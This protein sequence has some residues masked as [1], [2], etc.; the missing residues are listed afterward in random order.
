MN[1]KSLPYHQLPTT[2]APDLAAVLTGYHRR[3]VWWNFIRDVSRTILVVGA[4]ILAFCLLDRFVDID[5]RWRTPFPWIAFALL[6]VMLARTVGRLLGRADY[7]RIA[8]GL[9]RLANDDRDQLRTTLDFA[10]HEKAGGFFVAMSGA[11]ALA[12]WQ[13]QDGAAF[14]DGRRARSAAVSALIF[15]ALVV[16]LFQFQYLRGGLLWLR[17]L[18]PNGNFPRPSATWFSIEKPPAQPLRT[19]DDLPIRAALSGRKLDHPVP[20]LKALHP[21]GTSVTRKL[22]RDAQGSWQVRLTNLKGNFEWYLFM[23]DV[24]SEVYQT[25]VLPRPTVGKVEVGYA[26][27]KYSRLK[28][29]TETLR[30]RTVTALQGTKVKLK[31]HTNLELSRAIGLVDGE[32]VKFRIQRKNPRIAIL[33]LMLDQ[34]KKMTL[35]LRSVNGVRSKQELPFTFRAI[36]DNIP[37]VSIKNQ[38]AGKSFYVTD[39]I[40]LH[41][42]A[43]DDIGLAELMLKSVSIGGDRGDRHEVMIDIDLKKYGARE[44]EGRTILPVADLLPSRHANKVGLSLAAI[45][46]N[47]REGISQLVPITIAIDSFDRQLRLLLLSFD[48]DRNSHTPGRRG[49]NAIERSNSLL[50]SLKMIKG[51]LAVLSDSL[52]ADTPVGDNQAEVVKELQELLRGV[53]AGLPYGSYWFFDF[54]NASFLPRFRDYGSYAGCWSH[55]AAPGDTLHA[56]FDNAIRSANPKGE[57]AKMDAALEVAIQQPERVLKRLRI[58]RKTARLELCGYLAVK[59]ENSVTLAGR[60]QWDDPNFVVNTKKIARQIIDIMQKDIPQ[61]SLQPQMKMLATAAAADAAETAFHQALPDIA[62]LS[63]RFTTMAWEAGLERPDQG[64]DVAALLARRPLTSS[65]ANTMAAG[66]YL[67]VDDFETDEHQLLQLAFHFIHAYT[68]QRT[69]FQPLGESNAGAAVERTAYF[70]AFLALERL[71]SHAETFRHELVSGKSKAGKPPF[72]SHWLRLREDRLLVHRLI[73]PI[74]RN[75]ADLQKKAAP[76]LRSLTLVDRWLPP[77]DLDSKALPHTLRTWEVSAAECAAELNPVVQ[78]I[79]SE[80]NADIVAR[81]PLVADALDAYCRDLKNEIAHIEKIKNKEVWELAPM[82]VLKIRLMAIHAAIIKS[83]DFVELAAIYNAGDRDALDRL[84]PL[85]VL[86][87]KVVEHFEKKVE[88]IS[89]QTRQHYRPQHDERWLG[90]IREYNNVHDMLAPLSSILRVPRVDDDTVS[91]LLRQ[92]N[93]SYQHNQEATAV[94]NAVERGSSP[95]LAKV[96]LREASAGGTDF[97]GMLNEIY[98]STFLLHEALGQ[99]ADRQAVR[100][101]SLELTNRLHHFETLPNELNEMQELFADIHASDTINDPGHGEA[102]KADTALEQVGFAL[103]AADFLAD[104]KPMLDVPE[105][106]SMHHVGDHFTFFQTLDLGAL[107]RARARSTRQTEADRQR[108]RRTMSALALGVEGFDKSTVDWVL[109]ESEMNRRKA[110]LT[111][112][113]VGLGGIA[114]SE[115]FANLKLPKHLYLELK[116]ARAKAMPLLFQARCYDYLNRILENA[117]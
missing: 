81:L 6:L 75:N 33:Y 14:V 95:P 87:G 97:S 40:V 3:T 55:L 76:L 99:P 117:R 52:E 66:L 98:Y 48:G 114:P 107:Y 38:L 18:H 20:M 100:R 32:Q 71:Q 28:N 64:T 68:G 15:I 96:W 69:P 9:D 16:G 88:A 63:Q 57:L 93:I 47:G 11:K 22:M 116:R 29:K 67:Q 37:S 72:E 45:D 111:L 54:Q 65:V 115:D 25:T 53:G 90:K 113:R 4:P 102:P 105:K 112:T 61:T 30:G 104:L 34:N 2:L 59:L 79:L 49:D 89:L 35:D 109:G 70:K 82:R 56:D 92:L 42:R 101:L 7:D 108:V 46:T 44:A 8:H 77:V 19:G 41:H 24:R 39:T 1:M 94:R 60:D 51:R 106:S 80:I 58:M 74:V 50:S 103:R 62:E 26:Y 91:K 10:Y 86:V 110:G 83:I 31:I 23:A 12:T 21:D 36:A 78:Q 84:V 85:Y 17:F 73:A 5:G 43:H 27:P 13:R